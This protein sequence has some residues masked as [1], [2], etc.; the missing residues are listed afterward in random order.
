[1]NELRERKHEPERSYYF[2]LLSMRRDVTITK[3]MT[4]IKLVAACQVSLDLLSNG[5]TRH[6]K[7]VIEITVNDYLSK[8]KQ[9]LKK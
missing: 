8:S 7:A 5:N 6:N 9:K 1:M 3:A 2:S 4:R